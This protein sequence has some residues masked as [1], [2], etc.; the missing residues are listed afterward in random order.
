MFVFSIM[1]M[2]VLVMIILILCGLVILRLVLI[3]EFS[4]II[5]V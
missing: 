4:G 1:G 2:W 3:G 5:V